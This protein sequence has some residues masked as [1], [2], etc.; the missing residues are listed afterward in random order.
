[1]SV[2]QLY[3]FMEE[4]RARIPIETA[5]G[6]MNDMFDALRCAS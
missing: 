6:L 5:D 2:S 1:M 4:T 3:K